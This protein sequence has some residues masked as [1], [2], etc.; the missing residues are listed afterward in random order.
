MSEERTRTS[1][2]CVRFAPLPSN[3]FRSVW[4]ADTADGRGWMQTRPCSKKTIRAIRVIRGRISP[5]DPKQTLY[6]PGGG[7]I[8]S[9][10]RQ[11]LTGDGV[12]GGLG[13]G[14]YEVSN[15]G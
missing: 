11:R 15:D 8:Q 2:D 5:E 3:V 10:A 7:D 12:L 6:V 1:P 14:L 13:P 4:T 9:I